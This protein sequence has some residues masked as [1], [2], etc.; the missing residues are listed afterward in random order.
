MKLKAW[1]TSQFC[2][3]WRTRNRKSSLCGR[4]L[5]LSEA[6]LSFSA[7]ARETIQPVW[8]TFDPRIFFSFKIPAEDP[9]IK[10][11]FKLAELFPL[12]QQKSSVKHS[13]LKP[14]FVPVY[15]MMTGI[16]Y[17]KKTFL[18]LYNYV[19]FHHCLLTRRQ[20]SHNAFWPQEL[21]IC[22]IKP[23]EGK[24]PVPGLTHIVTKQHDVKTAMI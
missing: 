9:Q 8:K 10:T 15:M 18:S 19:L 4:I 21:G 16:M 17:L 5:K 6:R 2:E 13:R 11:S 7:L 14:R 24:G 20:S 23:I 22:P 12:L 1:L 3:G